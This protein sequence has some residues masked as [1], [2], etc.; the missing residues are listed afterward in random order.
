[1]ST[2]A[3]RRPG[4]AVGADGLTPRRRQVYRL[5]LRGLLSR[6]R[7]PGY[8]ELAAAMGLDPA[9]SANAPFQMV[10]ALARCGLVTLSSG[11][12]RLRL[13]GVR[14]E[15]AF[16]DSPAGLAARAV[17]DGSA[18][19]VPTWDSGLRRGVGPGSPLT[20]RQQEVYRTALSLLLAQ[21]CPPSLRELR[22]VM[23]MGCHHTADCN[24]VPL[25][26][27]GLVRRDGWRL[28]FPGVR[29]VA[30]FEDSEAG[31]KARVAWEGGAG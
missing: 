28:T 29:L 24:V 20:A 3:G 22:D 21:Q 1:M 7:F 5:L 14:L 16:D 25:A 13:D 11:W 30:V 6:Q 15:P 9:A 12:G 26:R 4:R 17:W 23:G 27:R 2:T 8:R 31:R 10:R 18:E 19:P